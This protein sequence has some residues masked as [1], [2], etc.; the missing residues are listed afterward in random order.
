MDAATRHGADLHAHATT[1]APRSPASVTYDA[2]TRTAT[3]TPVG[4]RSRYG[5]TLHR[6]RRGGAAGVTDAAGNPLA[7]DQRVELH[8]AAR[9]PVH[10]LRADRGPARRRDRRLARSRSA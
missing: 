8:H 6:D 5:R 7:A 10:G 4:A 3:L 9:L 2:A 1:S